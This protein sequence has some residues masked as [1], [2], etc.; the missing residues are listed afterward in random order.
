MSFQSENTQVTHD[1]PDPDPCDRN[2]WA[3]WI[4]ILI[5]NYVYD[6]Y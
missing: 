6:T 3:S 5:C 1:V 2:F 4:R